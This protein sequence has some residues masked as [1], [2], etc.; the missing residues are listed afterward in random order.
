MPT[1][2]RVDGLAELERRL[3]SLGEEYGYKAAISPVRAALRQ[4]ANVIQKAAKAKVAVKS[5]TLR[6]NIIVTS[7]GARPAAGMID[8]KVTIR[9]KAKGYKDNARNRRS[10]K[11]GGAY[12]NYG[13]LFY[14]RFLEFGTS[15]QM[16]QQFMTPAFEENKEAVLPIIRDQLAAAIDKSV[17]K[18]GA[19]PTS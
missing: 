8:M 4:G 16:R 19:M 13:P 7:Q 9:A 14:A 3:L 6:D 5:G 11:V 18:F 17:A 2:V 1:L 12:Q 10:G 15:H